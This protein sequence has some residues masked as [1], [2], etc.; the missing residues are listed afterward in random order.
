MNGIPAKPEKEFKVG[1]VRAA[2]W[3]NPR[4]GSD[5]KAFNSYKVILERTYRDNMGSFKTTPSLDINDIPKA[6]LALKKA[7]E[8][9]TITGGPQAETG[10]NEE[11]WNFRSA[12]RIP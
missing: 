11:P 3:A 1:A 2:I 4:H 6:I 12:E 9:L 7:Y 5:G 8:Y 10:E